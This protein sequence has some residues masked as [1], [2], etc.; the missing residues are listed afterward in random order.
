MRR[1][2][3]SNSLVPCILQSCSFL[4]LA[5]LRP[6]R[7]R[8]TGRATVQAGRKS[9]PYTPPPDQMIYV[10]T[11]PKDK[12]VAVTA[13]ISMSRLPPNSLILRTP[14]RRW[15]TSAT[16]RRQPRPRRY[17]DPRYRKV[18]QVDPPVA[19]QAAGKAATGAI[20]GALGGLISGGGG[21]GAAQE[22][23]GSSLWSDRRSGTPTG[24]STSRSNLKSPAE[25]RHSD[26]PGHQRHLRSRDNK[27]GR[28]HRQHHRRLHRS[29]LPRK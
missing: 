18:T 10:R 20:L 7:P 13:P 26:R 1:T 9:Q 19:G 29:A 4:F 27:S 14:T 21:Q 23:P 11:G 24:S 12:T 16:I 2:P 5:S 3:L 6:S 17:P 28:V 25:G 8:P 15:K 22:Q